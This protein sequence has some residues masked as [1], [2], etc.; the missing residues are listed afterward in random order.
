MNYK[1]LVLSLFCVSAFVALSAGGDSS[2]VRVVTKAPALRTFE[3]R[4]TVQGTIEAHTVVN[5][6][7]RVPGNIERLSVDEG[8]VVKAGETELFAIDAESLSNQVVVANQ[9]LLVAKSNVSVSEANCEKIKAE[10]TKAA[11]DAA[12]YERLH[13]DG[14]V[15]DNEYEGAMTQNAVAK[16]GEAVGNAQRELALSQMYQAEAQLKIAKKALADATIFAPISGAVSERKSEVG[17]FVGAGTTILTLVGTDDLECAAFLPAESF[18]DIIPGKTKFRVGDAVG[19][20]SRKSPTIN[21]TLR[22]FEVK[23]KVEGDEF[24]PGMAADMTC[25]FESHD[26]LAIPSSAV[27][28]RGG[29]NVVFVESGNKARMQEVTL[30]LKNDGFVEILSG[31][32][33]NDAVIVEGHTFVR[34]GGDIT[35]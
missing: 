1:G 13:K 14:R 18:A 5:V 24:A 29:K 17:E 31:L 21:T 15:T 19:I 4:I 6:A 27:L 32:S 7:A 28:V 16:A 34:D 20:I 2:A 26:G 25:V 35:K 3:R 10:A 11:L 23:G 8:D 30:G 12:R 33:A 9:A 22:T